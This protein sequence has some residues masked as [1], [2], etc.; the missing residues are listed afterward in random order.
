[1]ETDIVRI[2]IL[3]TGYQLPEE[4]I[5]SFFEMF[6]MSQPLTPGGD[7]GLAPTVAQ[8]IISLFGGNVSVRNLD[9]PGI[10]FETNL[11]LR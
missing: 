8:K 3:A 9:P 10:A 11:K 6:S 1:V 5:D 2:S 4:K 7:L